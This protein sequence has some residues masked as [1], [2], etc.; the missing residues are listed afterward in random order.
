MQ[1]N[2]VATVT[3]LVEVSSAATL[4]QPAEAYSVSPLVW[5]ARQ[6]LEQQGLALRII[7]QGADVNAA[8]DDGRTV[9]VSDGRFC[10]QQCAD[11]SIV[12]HMDAL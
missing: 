2:S 3:R 8:F 10:L 1:S 9:L 12:V 7:E 6:G 5:V 11:M 4:T